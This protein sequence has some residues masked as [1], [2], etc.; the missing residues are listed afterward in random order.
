M[1]K[2]SKTLAFKFLQ[3]CGGESIPASKLNHS[4]VAELIAEGIIIDT[5]TGR[6][7]SLL[8]LPVPANLHAFLLNRF[9]IQ[10]LEKYAQ[11]LRQEDVSRA[12]LVKSASDSKIKKV[13][14]FKGFLV[15]SYQP[16]KAVLN[17]AAFVV[18]PTA[19]TFQFIHDFE[20]FIPDPDVTIVGVE[21]AENFSQIHQQ[22]QLFHGIQ[23]LFV[24]RYPQ[25]QS[26][27]LIKW[28]QKIPNPYLH[29]GDFDFAGIGIYINEYKCYLKDRA[30]FFIP[31]HFE[32]LIAKVGSRRLYDLQKINFK[33]DHS[34]EPALLI[35]INLLHKYKKGLEQEAL[36][37]I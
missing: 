6:S 33:I 10:D 26:K 36:I 27:D 1:I 2:L 35:T 31:N 28:L 13:R 5:R 21:N 14:T 7:K 20:N 15:N 32:M 29:F 17:E 16:I 4:L 12:E 25:G 34:T 9:S 22:Q 11:S 8:T 18:N 23:P 19:G 37:F 30:Q 3:L 24:S